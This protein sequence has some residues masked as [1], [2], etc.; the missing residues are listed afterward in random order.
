MQE[1][2][3]ISLITQQYTEIWAAADL[4]QG[5]CTHTPLHIQCDCPAF[6]YERKSDHVTDDWIRPTFTS[7][8][9]VWPIVQVKTTGRDKRSNCWDGSRSKL[10]HLH[11]LFCAGLQFFYYKMSS[12]FFQLQFIFLI[13]HQEL[14]THCVH[15]G[16]CLK[17]ASTVG[18]KGKNTVVWKW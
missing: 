12:C 11:L 4:T 1:L 3:L 10:S 7:T 5:L 9:P 6:K 8:K 16:L 2:T 15:H 14:F 13:L 18:R 17:Y